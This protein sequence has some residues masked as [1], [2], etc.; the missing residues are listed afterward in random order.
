MSEG[1]LRGATRYDKRAVNY[2]A[3]LT[4]AAIMIRIHV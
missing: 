4:L 2:L 1:K 3:F